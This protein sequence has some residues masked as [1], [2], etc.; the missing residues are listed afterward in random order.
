MEQR[1]QC[2]LIPKDESSQNIIQFKTM[3]RGRYSSVCTS[4]KGKTAKCA[5]QVDECSKK[6]W[7]AQ[8]MS[9]KADCWVFRFFV[10]YS[11]CRDYSLQGITGVHKQRAIKTME[12]RVHQDSCGLRGVTQRCM[13]LG[14]RLGLDG[15]QSSGHLGVGVV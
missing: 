4:S 8:C 11:L 12:Q 10:V 1:P 9:H 6:G 14:P 7:Q 5:N 3:L 2:F 15:P 13:L